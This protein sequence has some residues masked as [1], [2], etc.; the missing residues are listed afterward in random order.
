LSL[1]LLS[2]TNRGR[3]IRLARRRYQQQ[4][5]PSVTLRRPLLVFRRHTRSRAVIVGPQL[6]R[7]PSFFSSKDQDGLCK[8]A[9]FCSSR[10]H[11]QGPP[12]T[13]STNPSCTHS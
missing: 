1:G 2:I 5:N 13:L 3:R 8:F 6:R 9:S 10:S 11:Y 12:S 4:Q 7:S